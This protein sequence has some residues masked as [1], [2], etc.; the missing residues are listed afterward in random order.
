MGAAGRRTGDHRRA[1]AELRLTNP[2]YPEVQV[3]LTLALSEGLVE[4]DLQAE[5]E[6]LEALAVD[7]SARADEHYLA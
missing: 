4:A 7:F 2:Q 6:G 1:G 3:R 5:G